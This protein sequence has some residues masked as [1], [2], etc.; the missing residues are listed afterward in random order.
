MDDGVAVRYCR[1]W[2]DMATLLTVSRLV[3][4]FGDKRL[5]KTQGCELRRSDKKHTRSVLKAR[6]FCDRRSI[7]LKQAR[8]SCEF[9][10]SLIDCCFDKVDEEPTSLALSLVC[11]SS[12]CKTHK[13][14]E[15][16]LKRFRRYWVTALLDL[17]RGRDLRAPWS[18]CSWKQPSPK[19]L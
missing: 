8:S 5:C 6:P 11:S 3:Q 1:G 19:D 14:R 4:V 17:K 15:E 13:N 9:A 12:T 7:F 16:S 18:S 10:Q 2:P